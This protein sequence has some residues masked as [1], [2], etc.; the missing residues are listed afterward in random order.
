M[1]FKHVILPELN[2]KQI[3]E[4]SGKR[5][6]VTSEGNRYPSVTTMLSHFSRKSIQEWRNRIGQEE[7]NKI[8]RAA[9][10]RGTKL[11]KIVEKYLANEDMEI[12]NQFQA[13]LFKSI[14][15][16]LN[17]IDNIHLQEKYLYSNYL[18]LAGTVDCI[19]EYKGKLSVIDFKTSSRQ[20]QEDWIES[21]FV[22]TAAYA[23]M[24][25]E[26]YKIPVPRIT[27]IIAVENDY[28][29]IFH[30]KR[31]DYAGKLLKMRDEYEWST[32]D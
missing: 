5:F 27:I 26:R 11:H 8:S 14:I 7:A 18:R 22:Q 4:D 23:I 3:T 24:F 31:D 13:E 21:Y 19:A 6:Y 25:E 20:K 30:K 16:Y 32:K 28:P 2:I 12:T 10:N 1:N 15:P 17:Y 9:S 29:Q